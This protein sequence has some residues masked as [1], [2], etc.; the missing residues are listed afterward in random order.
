LLTFGANKKKVIGYNQSHSRSTMTSRA[1]CVL[2]IS[3]IITITSHNVDGS[4][5]SIVVNFITA[6]LWYFS[7]FWSLGKYFFVWYARKTLAY[8]KIF[9]LK[10][11]TNSNTNSWLPLQA[12]WTFTLVESSWNNRM[13]YTVNDK[14][15]IPHQQLFQTAKW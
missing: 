3:R 13:L 4:I 7:Y 6:D 2:F 14:Q 11:S 12:K 9:L 15:L 1:T 5:D 8:N 10:D